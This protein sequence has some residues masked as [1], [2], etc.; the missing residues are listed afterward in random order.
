MF[1]RILGTITVFG[2]V[3][4]ATIAFGGASPA[5]A[6]PCSGTDGGTGY[7]TAPALVSAGGVSGTTTEDLASFAATYNRIF[8]DNC[9]GFIPPANFHYDQCLQDRLFWIAEDPS[10]DPASAWGHNAPRSDG[11]AFVGCDGNLAGGFGYTGKTAADMWWMSP[12]HRASLFRP[13][14]TANHASICV[15]FAM[16]HGGVPDEPGGFSRVSAVRH[17]C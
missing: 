17:P 12:S 16:T 3:L 9:L 8:I 1:T 6:V 13:G 14:S 10:T 7:G 5:A 15:G 4:A 11:A 2:A